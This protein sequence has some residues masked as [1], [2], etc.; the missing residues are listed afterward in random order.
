MNALRNFIRFYA[1]TVAAVCR[2]AYTW[3]RR[4]TTDSNV[5]EAYGITYTAHD[6]LKDLATLA[7]C[8]SYTAACWVPLH[9]H[10][11]RILRAHVDAYAQAQPEDAKRA[12][13]A[14]EGGYYFID[15][16]V[17]LP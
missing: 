1:A 17:P 7:N 2:G 6:Y 4:R 8:G 3:Q 13:A 5:P 10:E 16:P 12:R 11:R 9:A 14:H 15:W